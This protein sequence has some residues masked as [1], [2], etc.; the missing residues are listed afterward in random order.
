[1]IKFAFAFLLTIGIMAGLGASALSLPSVNVSGPV[2]ITVRGVKVAAPNT[3][4]VLEPE[5]VEDCRTIWNLNFPDDFTEWQEGESGKLFLSM[6]PRSVCFSLFVVPN[7]QNKPLKNI[8]YLLKSEVI[9]PE[10]DE[11]PTARFSKT[12]FLVLVE[13]SATRGADVAKLVGSEFWQQGLKNSGYN[14][15]L[16]HD[17]DSEQGRLFIE[18][19]ISFSSFSEVPFLAIMSADGNFIESFPLKDITEIREGLIRD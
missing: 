9:K 10:P 3:L 5:G 15:P 6:P 12:D 8:R 1:M 13:E 11:T 2:D 16:T 4:V 17:K 18:A 19:A 7:D 14:K